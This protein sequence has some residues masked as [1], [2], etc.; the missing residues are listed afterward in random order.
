MVKKEKKVDNDVKRS[1]WTAEEDETLVKCLKENP[2]NF[3]KAFALCSIA[4]GR[5]ASAC[6]N[7]WYARVKHSDAT[8]YYTL[9][10][11]KY[12]RNS[13]TMTEDVKG[14]HSWLKD[15]WDK[16]SRLLFG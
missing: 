5:S 1:Q 12:G 16:V 2:E 15:V 13:R 14:E 3:K 7:R 6:A 9:S 8:V 11:K 10:E 4:T